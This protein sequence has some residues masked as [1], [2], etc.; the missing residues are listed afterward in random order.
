MEK[1]A[2][3]NNGVTLYD[4]F[5]HHPSAIHTTLNGLKLAKIKGRI[6]AVIEPR[7]N[8]M[9]LGSMKKD[10]VESLQNAD[11]V[12]CYSN[13]ITW[14]AKELFAHSENIIVS[15]NIELIAQEIAQDKQTED[16]IVFMSNGN[17][18]NI[19]TKV[20]NLLQ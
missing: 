14:D 19:Q 11:K 17:F 3:L 15:D 16:Q 9:K 1:I 12:Y 18:S 20:I 7:S 2:V 4:D 13:N 8:T 10:L 5:A 6:I